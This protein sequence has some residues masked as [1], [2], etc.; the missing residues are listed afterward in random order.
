ST[1][2]AHP[3]NISEA[4]STPKTLIEDEHL[5]HPVIAAGPG[6]TLTAFWESAEAIYYSHYRKDAWTSPI[7]LSGG[8]QPSAAYDTRGDLH[9]AF[10]NN[11]SGQYEIY[12][13]HRTN[14]SWTLPLNVSST[15]GR[16]SWPCILVAP[17]GKRHLVW[18]DDTP[19]YAMIY[20][21]MEL[22]EWQWQSAPIPNAAGRRPVATFDANGRLHLCFQTSDDALSG[23][24]I[25][26]TQLWNGEWSTPRQLSDGQH[27]AGFPRVNASN[28]GE[29]HVVWRERWVD[30]DRIMTALY[31]QDEW[32]AATTISPPLDRGS[33]LS[34]AQARGGWVQCIWDYMETVEHA[35]CAEGIWDGVELVGAENYRPWS[36]A[37][38]VDDANQAHAL[39]V[40][41]REGRM[42]LR[43]CVRE[44]LAPHQT[45][46]P[47][48][49]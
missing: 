48:V 30:Q 3:A 17:D 33:A 42:Q 39:W 28:T 19:G 35:H 2:I 41:G 43:H 34:A 15:P 40:V 36:L 44:P 16:S 32:S 6:S 21:A 22:S 13:T 11:F 26:Y 24:D 1:K 4:W 12:V 46:L 20:H 38:A 31:R 8:I 10:A 9:V 7:R 14:P 25:V 49:T 45:F 47:F 29:V 37:L 27:P 23:G 18:Q 5:Q